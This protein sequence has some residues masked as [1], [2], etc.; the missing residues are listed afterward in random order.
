MENKERVL[1]Q[2]L[3][4]SLQKKFP[5]VETGEDESITVPAEKLIN[6]MQELKE[7]PDF[8]F[9]MLTNLTA[10]DYDEYFAV[11]YHL[12]SLQYGFTLAV[13]VKAEK[14]NPELPSVVSIWGSADWQEREVYDLMGI[15]FNGHPNLK[16]ILLDDHFEGHPLRK[17]YK[18]VGG[19]E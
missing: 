2:K 3:I 17:D 10:V 12:V 13:K 15:T 7:N 9:D 11:V 14:E 4:D 5:D 19:R 18:V 1:N 16:R 8:G 6:F